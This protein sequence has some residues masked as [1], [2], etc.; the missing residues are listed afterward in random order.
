MSTRT[1]SPRTSAAVKSIARL[2]DSADTLNRSL[3]KQLEGTA[4]G[5]RLRSL[6]EDGRNAFDAQGIPSRRL[7]DWKGTSLAPLEAFDFARLGSEPSDSSEH[8]RILDS[9]ADLLANADL[10]LIDGRLAR[11]TVSPPTGIK[12]F[13]LSELASDD[14]QEAV[15]SR[16]GALADSKVDGLT[17]LQSGLLEDIAIVRVSANTQ[18]DRPIRIALLQTGSATGPTASF[19]R[20]LVLAERG[21]QATVAISHHHAKTSASEATTAG[22]T[23]FVAEYFVEDGAQLEVVEVQAPTADQVHVTQAHAKLGRDARFDSHVLSLG[24]G[25]TRSELAIRLSEPGAATNMRGFFLGRG[26]GHVDH[27]TTADHEAA[28]CTSDEEYRGVLGDRSRGVFRGRVIVRPD[29]QKTDARQSNPNLLL[30]DRASIDTKP[31]LEIYADDVKA[32]HGSTI[33]QLDADALFFLRARGISELDARLLLTRGFA[34]EIVDGISDASLREEVGG[35]VDEALDAL[36]SAEPESPT[37]N[38]KG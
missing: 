14:E 8:S 37:G 28:H 5:E 13:A 1:D 21:A 12:A 6:S 16:L 4:L 10:V 30:S 36:T 17:A 25:L 20:I 27:F 35:R 19:P 7:E 18:S 23:G 32:S 31:Q 2:R 29:A 9:E 11:G 15:I 38:R 26:D 34:K 3:A 33:G 24:V 22:Y